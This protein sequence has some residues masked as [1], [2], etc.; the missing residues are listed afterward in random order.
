[1]ITGV[2]FG[3]NVTVAEANLSVSTLLV[4]VT[5]TVCCFEIVAGAV[6]RPVELIVPT[7]GLID[8]VTASLPGSSTLAVNCCVCPP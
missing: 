4:A 1:V 3:F 5:I 6:Y 7:E 2:A 8:H